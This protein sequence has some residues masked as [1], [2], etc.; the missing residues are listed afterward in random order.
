MGCK[1]LHVFAVLAKCIYYFVNVATINN[2]ARINTDIAM[3]IFLAFFLSIT[4]LQMGERLHPA[5]KCPIKL[6]VISQ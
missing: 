4:T 5:V 3:S 2:R 1:L 6:T